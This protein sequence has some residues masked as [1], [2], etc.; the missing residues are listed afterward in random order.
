MPR[1]IEGY[2]FSLKRDNNV[3]L[4]ES[5]IWPGFRRPSFVGSC[6]SFPVDRTATTGR[7]KAIVVLKQT[8]IYK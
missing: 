5:K 4:F 3:V 1:S 6:N 2:P 7:L 8:S